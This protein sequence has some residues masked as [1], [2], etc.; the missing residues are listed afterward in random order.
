MPPEARL[1]TPG[2]ATEPAVAKP[3]FLVAIANAALKAPRAAARR[4]RDLP[5][6][7]LHRRR[8]E[9]ARETVRRLAPLRSVVFLCYGNVCRSPFAAAVFDRLARQ[10]ARIKA[11]VSS[12]GFVG[13]GRQPPQEALAAGLRRSYELDD[14]RSQLATPTILRGADLIVVMSIEQARAA[15]LTGGAPRAAIVVLGDFDPAPIDR[16]TILDPWGMRSSAFDQ[17]YDRIERC[18]RELVAAIDVE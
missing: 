7:A 17:S 1:Q 3:R 16:R 5:D 11:T 15:Y 14:H 12:A 13:P 8:R 2:S 6:R 4:V 10:S 9:R 18:V